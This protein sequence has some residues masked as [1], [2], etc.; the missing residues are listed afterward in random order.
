MVT[1]DPLDEIDFL[2][3]R[4]GIGEK[5]MT[6]NSHMPSLRFIARAN[7]RARLTATMKRAHGHYA[8]PC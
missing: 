1:M 4:N 6:T 7:Y 8:E 2:N 3:E 5:L